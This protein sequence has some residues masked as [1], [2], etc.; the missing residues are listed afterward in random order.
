MRDGKVALL[1]RNG[2]DAETYFPRLLTPP[3]WIEAREAIVDGEVVALDEHGRPGLLAAPGAHQR[4]PDR[5]GRWRSS[6]RPSTS[7]TSTAARSLD[8]PLEERKKL[9]ELVL[10]PRRAGAVREPHRAEGV[11]F[12][13]AAKAQRLEGDRRQASAVALRAGPPRAEWLKMKARPEQE[14]VVGGWTPGEGTARRSW[15]RSSS[16]STRASE[17][18]FSGKVGSGFDGRTRKE[19]RKGLEE[20]ETDAPPFD[21]PPPPDYRGRWGGDLAG[22]AMDPA[23]ARDPCRARRLVAGRDGP[24][25]GV[26]GPRARARPA[27]GRPRAARCDPATSRGGARPTRCRTR[28][29]CPIRAASARMRDATP[30]T[31]RAASKTATVDPALAWYAC[32]TRGPASDRRRGPLGG[33]RPGAQ[34]HE[35]RQGAVPPREAST[36]RRSRSASSSATS[37]GSRRRCCRTCGPAAQPAALPE[38]GREARASGRRTSRLGAEVAH[39]LARDGLPGARGP[40]RRTT[41]WSRTGRR[42]CACSATSP[43]SRSTRGRRRIEDPWH[44]D[45][46]AHRHRPRHED[47]VGRDGDAREALP[48]SAGASRRGGVPED[49]GSRGIQAL[50]PIEPRQYKYADTSAWVEKLSRAVGA[51][52]PS[53][54]RG[55][56]RRP[57]AAARPAS[58]TPRTRRSRRSSR[59]TRSGRGRAPRSPRRSRWEELDDPALRPDRWTADD[60][61]RARRRGRRPVGRPPGRPP[62]AA[63]L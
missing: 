22:V 24:A 2:N 54:C 29:A 59:R 53:S 7:C 3:T 4:G 46:R 30:K 31:R 44:A 61:A 6:T 27:R 57:T 43:R 25:D 19:L 16:A 18:R 8:V 12:F 58:T 41:I 56:G 50:I 5:A 39:D 35:P 38:R 36:S 9:L 42:R 20:L 32:R 26:Q 63:A 21:P 47:D 40:R 51:T 37:R 52:V 49:T 48:D 45:V 23:G 1:T 14:L 10:R 33:R 62:G 13:Q 28:R 11:A 60:P 34:A 17:L 55:S 15:V